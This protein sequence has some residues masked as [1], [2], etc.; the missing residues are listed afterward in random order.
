M[1][2]CRGLHLTLELQLHVDRLLLQLLESG[3]LGGNILHHHSH[4]VE[5]EWICNLNLVGN[6][7]PLLG[8]L[9]SSL[10]A[11]VWAARSSISTAI[12]WSER[13][14]VICI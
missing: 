12:L 14:S 1:L 11:A 13:R 3:H 9:E 4:P 10:R 7:L 2:P 6:T 8:D 5:C